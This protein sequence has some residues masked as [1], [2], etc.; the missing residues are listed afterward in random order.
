[1]AGNSTRVLQTYKLGTQ[2]SMS[3]KH[4]AIHKGS[5]FKVLPR[6]VQGDPI[7]HIHAHEEQAG[8]IWPLTCTV[9]GKSLEANWRDEHRTYKNQL[10]LQKASGN[11]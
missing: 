9:G 3:A 1:M 10:A 6:V 5:L 4:T 8:A 11:E 7:P 2:M